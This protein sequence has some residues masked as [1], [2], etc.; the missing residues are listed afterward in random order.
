MPFDSQEYNTIARRMLASLGPNGERWC[1]TTIA[2]ETGQACLIG[3]FLCVVR[4]E[5]PEELFA[6]LLLKGV[7]SL[8][9]AALADRAFHLLAS[10]CP[11]NGRL[12]P[13]TNIYTTNDKAKSRYDFASIRAVL[14]RMHELE[15][16]ALVKGA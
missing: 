13:I 6:F 7:D 8:Y 14:E 11:D 5:T 16:T 2:T 12:G 3:H 10:A 4:G 9:S 15:I 1:G